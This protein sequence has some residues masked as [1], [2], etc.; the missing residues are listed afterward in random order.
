MTFLLKLERFKFYLARFY[1]LK[2]KKTE[3]SSNSNLK[4]ILQYFKKI[5]LYLSFPSFYSLFMDIFSS[6]LTTHWTYIPRLLVLV[7][8]TILNLYLNFKWKDFFQRFKNIDVFVKVKKIHIPSGNIFSVNVF[9][10][11]N[12]IW[13]YLKV[14]LQYLKK[15]SCVFI[16]SRFY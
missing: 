3:I 2:F 8:I 10:N 12:F 9:K 11:S 5:S 14:I 4:L 7:L 15:I 1:E 6:P 16:L 13:Q